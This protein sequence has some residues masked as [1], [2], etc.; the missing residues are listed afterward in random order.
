M[1]AVEGYIG[2]N[3]EQ[4]IQMFNTS[5]NKKKGGQVGTIQQQVNSYTNATEE[6]LQSYANELMRDNELVA[7]LGLGVK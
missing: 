4:L 3:D 7:A 2:T 5:N 6:D 1:K